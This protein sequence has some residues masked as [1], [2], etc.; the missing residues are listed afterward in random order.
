MNKKI[1]ITVGMLVGLVA[2][3]A[4]G[5]W[6]FAHWYAQ[7]QIEGVA[8]QHH[9]D[10][11]KARL[12]GKRAKAKS[13]AQL[14]L[15]YYKEK[16]AQSYLVQRAFFALLDVE[17]DGETVDLI[18]H[19]LETRL[20]HI[21]ALNDRG[22]TALFYVASKG[23]VELVKLLLEHNANPNALSEH[24]AQIPLQGA[25]IKPEVVKVLLQQDAD[26]N[27]QMSDGR[28]VLMTVFKVL[29][30][31]FT[32]KDPQATI[33]K[34]KKIIDFLLAYGASPTIRDKQGRSAIDRLKELKETYTSNNVLNDR[35]SEQDR[36]NMLILCKEIEIEFE[37]RG[38]VTS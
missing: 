10:Q 11:M 34:C 2:V 18:K 22:Q 32:S 14:A 38:K 13:L 33:E 28:T 9:Q 25:L 6:V 19:L 1:T 5:V 23:D 4:G 31:A 35:F 16:H 27:V 26:P 21:D 20:V 24:G 17:Q 7:Q 30:K 36:K 3:V 15:K 37:S 12:S 29:E 8:S